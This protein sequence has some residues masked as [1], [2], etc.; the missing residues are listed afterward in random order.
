MSIPTRQ[1]QKRTAA[2]NDKIVFLVR[3]ILEVSY[4]LPLR[5]LTGRPLPYDEQGSHSG[6]GPSEHSRVPLLH[7]HE[8]F[9]E[10]VHAG[11]CGRREQTQGPSP[12]AV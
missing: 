11:R 12:Q 3:N 4:Q 1:K 5:V 10:G 7:V 6:Y 2:N 8:H 9:T